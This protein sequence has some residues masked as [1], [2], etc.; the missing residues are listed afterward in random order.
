MYNIDGLLLSCKYHRMYF[1]FFPLLRETVQ[2]FFFCFGYKDRSR[3]GLNQKC[4][5]E[6]ILTNGVF[7]YKDTKYFLSLEREI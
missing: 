1:Q 3:R 2:V 6:C 7:T 4:N 5:F